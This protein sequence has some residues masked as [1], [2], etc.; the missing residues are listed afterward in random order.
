MAAVTKHIG[1]NNMPIHIRVDFVKMSD[2]GFALMELESYDAEFIS[3][4]EKHLKVYA[5]AIADKVIAN[6]RERNKLHK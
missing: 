1:E 5:A 3:R 2:G 4:K 6:N